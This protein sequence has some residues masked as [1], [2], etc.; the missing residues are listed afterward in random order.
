MGGDDEHGITQ[1]VF[2][3]HCH[4]RARAAAGV[5]HAQYTCPPAIIANTTC[6][7]VLAALLDRLDAVLQLPSDKR[8]IVLGTAPAKPLIRLGKRF[9]ADAGERAEHGTRSKT[10]ST[11]VHKHV[12][13]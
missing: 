1:S 11:H 5:R 7:H 3:L 4:L 13:F 10:F 9:M 12:I 2:V 8:S 6:E